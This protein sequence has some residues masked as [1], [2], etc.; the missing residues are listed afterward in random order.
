MFKHF[1][2]LLLS[3]SF[4]LGVTSKEQG[5]A[6]IKSIHK[7]PIIYANVRRLEEADAYMARI[8]I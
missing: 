5:L 4:I 6:F 7:N 8:S 3:F 2:S 1:F